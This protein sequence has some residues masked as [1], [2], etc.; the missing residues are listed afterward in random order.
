MQNV[1]SHSKNLI[2]K[3]ILTLLILFVASAQMFAQAPSTNTTNSRRP[4]WV[5]LDMGG[6]WQASDMKAKGGIGWSFTLARYSKLDK[7]GPC[8]FG[9]RFR[10]LDGRDYGY[11]YH[12][13]TQTQLNADPTL[14]TLGSNID[15]ANT[16]GMAFANYRFRFDEFSYELIIGSNGLRKHGVLLYGFGGLGATHWK[17]TTNQSDN[18]GR[19]YNYTSITGNGN[20]A[21]VEPQLS[22][23]W[24]GDFGSSKYETV[25]QGSTSSGQWGI[26]PSAGVGFG[27]QF[28]NAVALGVEHRTTWAR[29][30][31][32]DGLSHGSDGLKSATNDLYNYDGFFVRWTFGGGS[33]NSKNTNTNANTNHPANPNNYTNNPPNPNNNNNNNTTTVVVPPNNNNNN[34]TNYNQPPSGYSPTVRFDVPSVEPYSTNIQSQQLVVHVEHVTGSNQISLLINNQPNSNFSFNTSTNTMVFS[35][36]LQN[37]TNIYRVTATNQYGS[38]YDVQTIIYGTVVNNNQQAGLPPQVTFTNPSGDPY[39]SAVASMNISATVLNV[40]SAANIQ[41]RLN[42]NPVYNF[43]FDSNSHLLTF[44]ANLATG[45]NFYE[46][47]G[48]NSLGSASDHVTINYNPVAAV[49]PPVVTITAPNVC[50]YAVKSAAYTITANITNVTTANQ[51]AIVFGNQTVSQFN[52]V[53][54]GN[55]ATISFPVTLVGGSNPFTITGTNTAGTNSK[56]CDITLKTT[57]QAPIVPPVVTITNPTSSPF[58]ATNQVFTFVATVLNVASQNEITVS[59]NNSLTNSWN[60]NMT[61]HVLNLTTNLNVGNNVLT[62]TAA[63]A[64]GSDTK[65]T[66]V[67]YSAPSV[68]P[69]VVNITIPSTNPFASTVSP[70]M[71]TAE[72]LNVTQANQITVKTLTGQDVPFSFNPG[73]H[74]VTFTANL[75]SGANYYNVTATNSAGTASDNTTIKY[76]GTASGTNAD[77]PANPQNNPGGGRG[78]TSNANANQ[79]SIVLVN[80]SSATSNTSSQE[81]TITMNVNGVNA[82]NEISV[83]VNGMH[84]MNFNFNSS[85]HVLSF[86]ASFVGGANTVDVSAQNSNGNASKSL[87]IT[88]VATGRTAPPNSDGN[89]GNTSKPKSSGTATAKPAATNSSSSTTA[90]AATSGRST[91][92]PQ[93]A[94]A[95]KPR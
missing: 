53:N 64:N 44:T 46:A 25:A 34:Q 4:L 72:V 3:R 35:H 47:I 82:S 18:S 70:V 68:A 12:A 78:N 2:M 87:T 61:S 75:V 15:Y 48:T 86:T 49:Q 5:G 41:V 56:S 11:S 80:P 73:S 26:M 65:S 20:N 60:Y 23:L 67:I 51:V 38:A 10:F 32:I 36:N 58:T 55:F 31:N 37:G 84:V 79:V 16:Q 83:R 57:S 52:F 54:N 7:T 1:L 21:T 33:S 85:T 27:Y 13:L 94:P 6:T 30:D 50:P 17:T 92:A 59:L 62:V 90:P 69:P 81:M 8:Y 66:T 14:S 9:W 39:T 76:I 93:A 88:Y 63:N 19:A 74:L 89:K 28:G 24:L 29:T 22:Q 91:T 42:G 77:S 45:S 43:S 95:S 71:V 40:S